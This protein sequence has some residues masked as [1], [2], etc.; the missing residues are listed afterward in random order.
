MEGKGY[1]RWVGRIQ[2]LLQFPRISI[3]LLNALME[4]ASIY[5]VPIKIIG[6][7]QQPKGHIVHPHE[8]PDWFVVVFKLRGVDNETV[9]SS[10]L[11]L[12]F[13]WPM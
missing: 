5:S 13:L 8:L 7:P 10:H 3:H 6:N 12:L 1:D 4:D 9:Q 2:A 11:R